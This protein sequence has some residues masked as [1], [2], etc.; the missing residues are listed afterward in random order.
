MV[1]LNQLV[2]KPR[3][4]KNRKVKSAALKLL[5]YR[6]RVSTLKHH[7]KPFVKGICTKILI[8]KPKKPNSAQRKLAKVLLKTGKTVFVSIPGIGHNLNDHATVLV[9]GG[10]VPDLPSVQYKMIRGKYDL[11]GVKNRRTSPSKYGVKTSTL[12]TTK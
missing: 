5:S 10:P 7:S 3:I 9:R 4:R 1:T 8:M 12:K 6:N 11:L 2:R